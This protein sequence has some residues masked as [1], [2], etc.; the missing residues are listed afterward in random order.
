MRVRI[1]GDHYAA[2]HRHLFPGDRD[3]HGA[4][5]FAHIGD[6]PSTLLV[7]DVELLVPGDFIPGDRGYRQI[8]APVI[9]RAANLAADWGMAL[10]TCH[11]HPGATTAVA[12]SADDKASHQRLFPHLTDVLDGPPAVSLVF[13]EASVAGEAWHRS[14]DVV[15]V[16]GLRVVGHQLLTLRP[17][18]IADTSGLDQRFDRQVRLFGPEGQHRLRALNVGVVGAGGGGSML[19]EQLA[20]LGVGT[21]TVVDYDI[22]KTHNL[23]RIVGATSKDA[24]LARKKIAVAARLVRNIDPTIDFRGID[25]DIA[26]V[27]VAARLAECDFLLLATDTITSR[28]VFNALVHSFIVPGVQVGAKVETTDGAVDQA[29]VAVRPVWPGRGCLQCA[30]LIDPMKLQEE[31]R[32]PE[33][34][35]AQNYLATPEVIDP[36]VVTLNGLAA[37]Q[38][39]NVLLFTVTGLA[40]PELLRH[41]YYF[42]ADATSKAVVERPDPQCRWCSGAQRSQF[43]RG[44]LAALPLRHGS[45]RR[46]AATIR[47]R[48]R[49]ILRLRSASAPR[50]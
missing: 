49:S 20:H 22:V 35:R 2:L 37:S 9:A 3:E 28:L 48:V 23:S 27:G 1:T 16:G 15:E 39:M 41:R 44:Q 4:I 8:P 13:G 10:V 46:E 40:D 38:A 6:D 18:P 36:S 12:F 25:G 5:L 17:R 32:S 50:C 11:S 42:P 19:I 7:R 47:Q 14:G 43:A 24:R 33:E 29:Y 45:A 30:G 34:R 21:I 26:D 31:S